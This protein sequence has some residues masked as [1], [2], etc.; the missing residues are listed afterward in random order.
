MGVE[1]WSKGESDAD[2]GLPDLTVLLVLSKATE[3][4][5]KYKGFPVIMEGCLLV[6][7]HPWHPGMYKAQALRNKENLTT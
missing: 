2:A 6:L 5:A 7:K 1:G 4:F 3:L